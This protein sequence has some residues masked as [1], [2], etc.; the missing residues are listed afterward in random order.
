MFYLVFFL[1]IINLIIIITFSV[2][3]RYST[4]Y[5]VYSSIKR[6]LPRSFAPFP[7]KHIGIKSNY[8]P[9]N[10][11]KRCEGLERFFN[12]ILGNL[13]VRNTPQMQAL[14]VPDGEV[15]DLTIPLI[16][17]Y[18]DSDSDEE[19]MTRHD[20]GIENEGDDYRIH[21]VLSEEEQISFE[22]VQEIEKMVGELMGEIFQLEKQSGLVK[23][24][25][26]LIEEYVFW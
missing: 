16:P 12:E 26:S 21:S 5:S 4:L 10:I 1:L 9:E 7:P 17:F 22:H 3:H 2:Y 20:R 18:G 8:D 6:L 15:N 25:S 13:R 24:I 19:E 14:F 11:R 23:K